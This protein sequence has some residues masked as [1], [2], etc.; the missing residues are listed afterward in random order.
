V[1]RAGTGYGKHRD[2]DA[3]GQQESSRELDCAVTRERLTGRARSRGREG[4][5]LEKTGGRRRSCTAGIE[6]RG[7]RASRE[8]RV[9]GDVHAWYGPIRAGAT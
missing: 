8:R 4:D 9:E 3:R 6:L 5:A 1:A 2:T 7:A